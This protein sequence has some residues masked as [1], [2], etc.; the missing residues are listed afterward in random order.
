[1][2]SIWQCPCPQCSSVAVWQCGCVAIYGQSCQ[3][4]SSKLHHRTLSHCVTL[5]QLSYHSIL[6]GKKV[7]KCLNVSSELKCSGC[8]DVF[9]VMVVGGG[10]DVGRVVAVLTI[11]P[12]AVTR[13]Q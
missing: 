5:W 2:V 7:P 9:H 8:R 12:S 11:W 1:M 6:L 13:T 10:H 4:T 3:Q